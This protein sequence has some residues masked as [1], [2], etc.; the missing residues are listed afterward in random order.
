MAGDRRSVLNA[1]GYAVPARRKGIRALDFNIVE[2][3]VGSVVRK[4]GRHASRIVNK[5]DNLS[6]GAAQPGITATLDVL[7]WG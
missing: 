4:D 2:Y 1:E 5:T 3:E 7:G 6:I